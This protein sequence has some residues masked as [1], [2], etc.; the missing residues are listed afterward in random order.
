MANEHTSLATKYRPKDWDSVAGQKIVKQIL[1]HQIDTNTFRQAYLLCGRWGSGKALKMDA[2]L[3]GEDGY[4]EMRDAK[5]G[6]KVYG[7]DGNLH[8]ITGVYP[9][10]KKECYKINFS[11]NTYAEC[12]IDHLWNIRQQNCNVT[13]GPHQWF[14]KSVRWLLEQELWTPYAVDEKGHK[15][16]WRRYCIPVTQPLNFPTADLPIPPYLMGQLLSDGGISKGELNLHIYE[17]DVRDKVKNI[18]ESEMNCTLVLDSDEYGDVGDFRIV[19]VNKG[20]NPLRSI[21]KELDVNKNALQKHI[22]KMY[23]YSDYEQRL[24]LLQGLFDGDGCVQGGQYT[25]ST[26]SEQLYNDMVFLIQSLGGI[27]SLIDGKIAFRTDENGNRINC[28]RNW[29]FAFKLTQDVKP[30]TSQKHTKRYGRGSSYNRSRL[31]RFIDSIEP[32]GEYETQCI[33]TDNP[34]GLFLM[35]NMIVTHNTTTARIMAKDINGTDHDVIEIDA[36]S[37]NGAEQVRAIAEEAQ[38][39]PLV[40]KYKIFIIDECFEPD[41]EVLTNEGFKRFADLNKSEKIAQYTELGNIEFV[42]P[43][44]YIERYHDGDMCKVHIKNGIDVL[45]T[46]NHMQPLFYPQSG[47]IRSTEI[48]QIKFAQSNRLI[49]SGKG[50]GLK[51]S[52]S[53]LDRL[54]IATSAD[55]YLYSSPKSGEYKLWSIRLKKSRK[56]GRILYL[57]DNCGVEWHEIKAEEGVRNFIYK[58]PSNIDKNLWQH[59]NIEDFSYEGAVDFISEVMEWDGS[60]KSGYDAYYS[61][62]VKQNVDFVAA[63]ASLAGFCCKQLIHEYENVNHK[64]EHALC[65]TK[66]FNRSAQS[67]VKETCEYSGKV[68]CVEVPSHMIVVR[69]NGYTFISGNCHLTSQAGWG[70][71]LKLIEEPPATAIFIF[72]TTDPQKIP[73]TILSRIQ[74]YDFTSIPKDEIVDRLK[75]IADQEHIDIDNDSLDYIAKAAN[76]G[77]RDAIS[78]LDKCNSIND[79]IRMEQVTSTLSLSDYGIQ[80]DLLKAMIN[81]DTEN[82]LKIVNSIFFSGK[83]LRTF[84]TQFM[85]CVCDVCNYYVFGKS[86]KYI[87]IPNIPENRQKMDDMTL[88]QCVPV[89]DW[90]KNLNALIR[91][92]NAPKDAILVE[93]MLWCKNL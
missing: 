74:R 88:D 70:C 15:N 19:G 9:Q 32:I 80:L 89:L 25:Y 39:K 47:K 52:L 46:P 87:S 22:P 36:A 77:M 7:E 29:E 34:S 6:M 92:N 76:G 2:K 72:A 53:Y 66:E 65:M 8:T 44:R 59:F 16:N 5:V 4:F 86:F 38:K 67:I 62:T 56:I 40:G 20:V 21:L 58:L 18:L 79:V 23:L 61:S 71:W 3:L 1:K 37:N 31:Y 83:D 27:V 82:A 50:S 17:Q 48:S 63:V 43:L 28:N 10:G 84:M 12:C 45:M 51:H 24:Q 30:F 90:A 60:Y 13:A 64:T 11:D 85:G 75:Y 78:M 68:Y 73:N 14:T 69:R 41:V 49:V 33:M 93:V 42:E 54:I 55:S 35:D 57:L 81:K 91:P 26:S